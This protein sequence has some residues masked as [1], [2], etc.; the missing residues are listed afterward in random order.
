M[1]QKSMNL[2]V[3]MNRVPDWILI[4]ESVC[5]PYQVMEQ[6]LVANGKHELMTR[7]TLKILRTKSATKIK[8]RL[9]KAQMIVGG[10]EWKDHKI[11]AQMQTAF[12]AFGIDD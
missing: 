1:G 6:A 12:Q 2:Q 7:L 9:L 10:L 11:L 3:L 4:P 5:V 8:Q